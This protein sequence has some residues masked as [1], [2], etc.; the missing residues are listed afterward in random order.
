MNKLCIDIFL[1]FPYIYFNI[2]MVISSSW[3]CF[4]LCC[5]RPH[6]AILRDYSGSAWGAWDRNQDNH[7]QG[8][9]TLGLLLFG[10]YV[11]TRNSFVSFVL[12]TG[13][14]QV[15]LLIPWASKWEWVGDRGQ[16]GFWRLN[17]GWL[18]KASTHIA[19]LSTSSLEVLD[20]SS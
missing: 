8:K 19:G 9:N 16:I 6:S 1:H 5:F 15:S 2:N 18:Q 7:V 11:W 13:C 14:I 17:L 20:N 10:V 3:S 4:V 12:F